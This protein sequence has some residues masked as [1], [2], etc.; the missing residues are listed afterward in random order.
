MLPPL[1][2]EEYGAAS[3]AS[4]D[5]VLTPLL[6]E[7]CGAA[8]PGFQRNAVLPP[9]LSEEY[10]AA[11][12]ASSDTVLTPLPPVEYGAASPTCCLQRNTK[13]PPEVHWVCRPTTAYVTSGQHHMFKK[14]KLE[15]CSG[16]RHKYY[17]KRLLLV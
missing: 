8:S 9:L 4:S 10:G 11:S 3:P 14:K 15:A 17:T 12:P 2:P 6:S 16:N 5:T 1:L 7:E 13:L